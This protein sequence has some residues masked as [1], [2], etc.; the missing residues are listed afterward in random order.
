MA[1]FKIALT[2]LNALFWASL[3]SSTKLTLLS[4]PI[5]SDLF[6]LIIKPCGKKLKVKTSLEIY[7]AR[8]KI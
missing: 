4:N 3:V 7:A 6:G 5:L 2:S 8:L 1:K